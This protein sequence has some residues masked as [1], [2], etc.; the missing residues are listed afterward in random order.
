[1]KP[2]ISLVTATKNNQDTIEK[3]FRSVKGVVD[4]IV[5]VDN[6]SVDN[7]L[8]IAKKYQA[9]V[10][11]YH[12]DNLG[13]QY[14]KGV[15]QAKNQWILILDSDESLSQPLRKELQF[16]LAK[17]RL[18]NQ[19]DVY[20]LPFQSYFFGKKLQYGGENYR[21]YCLFK[22]NKLIISSS[23]IHQEYYP[24]TKKIGFLKKK[25]NHYSY[26]NLFQ[27]INKFSFY[28][29][30]SAKIKFRNGE[31]SSLKKLTLYPLHMF[32]ARFIKDQGYKDGGFRFLLD[33][34][35]AYMEALTYIYLLYYQL[36]TKR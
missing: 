35:F 15:S 2:G 28:A 25:V 31:R 3:T 23:K 14:Q 22:K 16:L 7:T 17:P 5:V 32:Y 21:K 36:F 6:G 34:L 9:K 10:V 33:L 8:K 30:E 13:R 11:R 24:K 4:E 1:M 19:F 18:F 27:I 12:G 20:S 29:K 26:R